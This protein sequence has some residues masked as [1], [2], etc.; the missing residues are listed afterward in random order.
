[1]L[2]CV[3][4]CCAVLLSAKRCYAVLLS[5]VLCCSVLYGALLCCLVRCCAA[6]CYTVRC[7]TAGSSDHVVLRNLTTFCFSHLC[8]VRHRFSVE[9]AITSQQMAP[10]RLCRRYQPRLGIGRQSRLSR[11]RQLSIDGER[12]GYTTSGWAPSLYRLECE[13]ATSDSYFGAPRSFRC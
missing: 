9:G 7:C 12:T 4:E 3:T 6:R 8:E 11:R 10:P 2:C 1:M 5:A 13:L